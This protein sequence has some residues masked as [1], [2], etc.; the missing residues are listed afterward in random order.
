M[1]FLVFSNSYNYHFL[2]NGMDVVEVNSNDNV[3]YFFMKYP[4]Q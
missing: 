2:V 3:D 4:W 1:G